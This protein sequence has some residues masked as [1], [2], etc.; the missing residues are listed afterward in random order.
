M[1]RRRKRRS[2]PRWLPLVAAGLALF[3]LGLLLGRGRLAE[4]FESWRGERERAADEA[5]VPPQ[6]GAPGRPASPP[7]RPAAPRARVVPASS[8]APIARVA[9]VIDDLGP[10]LRPVERLLALGLPISYALLPHQ[11]RTAAV[12]ARLA[13]AG[14]EILCHLPM[15]AE[16]DADPGIGALIAGMPAAE[17]ERLAIAAIDGVP[18]AVGVNNHMG[19]RLTADRLA[20]STVLEVVA[21]RRLFFLDSRTTPDSVGAELAREM[22]VPQASRDVFLDPDP[23]PEAVRE[24]FERWLEVASERGAAIAIGH[25]HAVTLELLERELPALRERGFELVPVS[26]L[27]ERPETLPE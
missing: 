23:D 1:A 13:A 7:A 22:G 12:A 20:M 27:L 8:P 6:S 5:V 4:R 3:A 15:E 11:P 21:R 24:Q 25:P 26:Y 9:M 16:G 18:G 10:D 2:L 19:S 17:L 14:A